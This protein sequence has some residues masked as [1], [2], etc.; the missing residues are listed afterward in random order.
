MKSWWKEG[1]WTLKKTIVGFIGNEAKHEEKEI[2]WW[3]WC[4]VKISTMMLNPYIAVLTA[5]HF[6]QFIYGKRK[7]LK[8]DHEP[9]KYLVHAEDLS[10]TIERWVDRLMK[11]DI[12]VEYRKGKLNGNADALSRVVDEEKLEEVESVEEE[13]V[14][15]TQS[16]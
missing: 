8:T 16:I 9:L 15:I 7:I 5:D 11:F 14:E 1:F 4:V 10:G 12:V 13:K 6:K 3:T 2:T